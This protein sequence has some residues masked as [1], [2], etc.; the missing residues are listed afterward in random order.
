[1]KVHIA[2]DLKAGKVVGFEVT[3][4]RG[5]DIKEGLKILKELYENTKRSNKRIRNMIH[6]RYLII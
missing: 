4:E 1:M 6:M 3:D 2:Y 5:Q